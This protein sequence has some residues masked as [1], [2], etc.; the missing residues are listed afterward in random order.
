MTR[1]LRAAFVLTMM[2]AFAVPAHANLVVN[3]GFETGTFPP[4]TQG[5]NLVL[6]AVSP[7]NPHTGTFA[8]ALGPID[9][10]GFLTQ[11]LATISGQSYSLDFWLSSDGGTPNHFSASWNGSLLFNEV[12]IL[13]HPYALNSFTVIGTG[14]D[15]LKF[16]FHNNP[17]F[18]WLDD[19]SVQASGGPVIPEPGTLILVG[20]GLIALARRRRASH[21]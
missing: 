1:T 16:G 9:T 18:L 14:S 4:W 21:A 10:D 12:N 8:A 13:A 19:V 5:G 7:I 3:G 6:T 17:G 11:I 20:S 2:A 15:T